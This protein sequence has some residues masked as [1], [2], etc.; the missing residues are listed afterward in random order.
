MLTVHVAYCAMAKIVRSF[1]PE[2]I[3]AAVDSLP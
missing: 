2:M 1:E 3:K